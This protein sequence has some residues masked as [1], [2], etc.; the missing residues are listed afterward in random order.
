MRG[1]GHDCKTRGM[2]TTA[3]KNLWYL[4]CTLKNSDRQNNPKY[5]KILAK[6]NFFFLKSM[7]TAVLIL[8]KKWFTFLHLIVCHRER[9]VASGLYRVSKRCGTCCV[10][11]ITY[12]RW[13]NGSRRCRQKHQSKA[14]PTLWSQGLIKCQR[15]PTTLVQVAA[16]S[17]YGTIVIS[18]GLLSLEQK[19]T[20]VH[21]VKECEDPW[22]K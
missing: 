16:S 13:R 20:A 10:Y 6:T 17:S 4:F 1:H 12:C 15:G 18:P 19:N 14:R 7:V 22:I 2:R 21:Y 11:L 5:W 3:L 9:D 8:L